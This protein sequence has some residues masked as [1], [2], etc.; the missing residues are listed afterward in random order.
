MLVARLYGVMWFL[1]AAVGGALYL[2]DSLT[3]ATTMILGFIAS[4]LAGA[5]ILVVYPTMMT[6][7]VSQHRKT[8]R[9]ASHKKTA[10]NKLQRAG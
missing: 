1:T 2:T 7:H 6:E 4:V 3:F 10:L 9:D 5:G 8:P